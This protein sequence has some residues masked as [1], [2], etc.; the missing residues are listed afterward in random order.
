M[1]DRRHPSVIRK[2]AIAL[3]LLGAL[4][5]G[6]FAA[7]AQARSRPTKAVRAIIVRVEQHALVLRALDGSKQRVAIPARTAISLDGKPVILSALR[8]GDI[9]IVMPRGRGRGAA[10]QIRA[11]SP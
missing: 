11:F 7:P 4:F 6:A 2:T 3:L 10:I 1:T 9:V 8:P 5:V